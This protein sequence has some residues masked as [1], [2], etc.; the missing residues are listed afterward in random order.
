MLLYVRIFVTENLDLIISFF[1]LRSFHGIGNERRKKNGFN[2]E[3]ITFFFV[4]KEKT[5][6]QHHT[7]PGWSPTPVLS[8]LKQG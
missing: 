2:A 7:V 6:I 3:K 8:G 1:I 5:W 4:W